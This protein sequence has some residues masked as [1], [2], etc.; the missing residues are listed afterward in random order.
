MSLATTIESSRSTLGSVRRL[1]S[2]L[3]VTWSL[4]SSNCVW[5]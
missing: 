5:I 3:A 1:T 2:S 4:T